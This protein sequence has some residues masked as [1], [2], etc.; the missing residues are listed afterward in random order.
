MLSFATTLISAAGHAQ[1]GGRGGASVFTQGLVVASGQAL[2][3]IPASASTLV[4]AS[5]DRAVSTTG[6][7]RAPCPEPATHRGPEL[8]ARVR[9]MA[10]SGGVGAVIFPFDLEVWPCARAATF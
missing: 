4:L 1:W 7:S 10:L 6:G 2:V 3:S 5:A 9:W 8:L